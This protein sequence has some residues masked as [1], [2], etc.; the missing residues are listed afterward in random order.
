MS[1]AAAIRFLSEHIGCVFHTRQVRPDGPVWEPGLRTLSRKGTQSFRLDESTVEFTPAH[2]V[3]QVTD[4]S[5]TVDFTTDT[6]ADTDAG[7]VRVV[8]TTTY[9]L[10]P[11]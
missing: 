5:V 9:T 7:G 3:T 1:K 11:F 2:R 4:T 10:A 8:H 6:G